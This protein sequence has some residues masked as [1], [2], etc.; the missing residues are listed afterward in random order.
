VGAMIQVDPFLYKILLALCLVI[1][2][3]RILFNPKSDYVTVK[4]AEWYYL[5]PVGIILGFFSGMIGIGGGILL[6]PLL[7][8]F[9]WS[10]IKQSAGISAAFIFLNSLSGITALAGNGNI[11]GMDTLG[12]VFAAILGG[13]TGSFLGSNKLT[14]SG[15]KYIL[16]N[17]LLFAAA[18][19]ILF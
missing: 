1:A 3:G 13:I 8:L 15:L 18:K 10:T 6:S 19:L 16:A 5:L 12:W 7:I 9:R 4:N 2:V 17:V 11:P 14:V